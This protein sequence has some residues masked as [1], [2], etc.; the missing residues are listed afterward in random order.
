MYAGLARAFASH[1]QS[2]HVEEDP[3]QVL[4]IKSLW[5]RQNKRLL[6]AFFGYAVRSNLVFVCPF[7]MI[8]IL[9]PSPPEF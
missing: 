9:N 5:T 3:E 7:L 2:M 6:D 8:Q 1:K 4:D